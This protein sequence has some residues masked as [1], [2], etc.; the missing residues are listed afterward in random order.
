[1]HFMYV[2]GEHDI[3]AG[4][5]ILINVE[6]IHHNEKYYPDPYKFNPEHFTPEAESQRPLLSFL[7]FSHGP[8]NCI[9]MSHTYFLFL[10]N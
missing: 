10:S 7:P 3:P 4:T 5:A 1:M 2:S 9:G 6:Q 8:R